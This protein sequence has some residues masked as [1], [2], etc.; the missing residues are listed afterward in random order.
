MQ[1]IAIVRELNPGEGRMMDGEEEVEF[2][3]FYFSEGCLV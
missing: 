2:G 1:P 3:T